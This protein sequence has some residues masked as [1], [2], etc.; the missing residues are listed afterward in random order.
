[1]IR[2]NL[3]L[4]L[5]I[6]LP[7]LLVSAVGVGGYVAFT[8]A[9]VDPI[10]PADA[11]IVLG[12]EHDGREAYGISLAER[13]VA[14]TVVLSNPYGAADPTMKKYCGVETDT[15]SVLCEEPEPSTTR[16]EAIFTQ[17]L[18]EERGWDH[19]VV[20]SWRYHLPRARYIFD[21]CFAGE[22]T[23]QAVPRTYDFSLVH[24]EYTYLYQLAGFTK[25]AIQGDC[26][27]LR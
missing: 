24:W 1:V 22:V 9:P 20:V 10:T 13:G 16:G 23:M 6:V 7:V 15:Y 5:A 19:V 4:V 27:N 8:K 12:G 17:Q 2:R 26:Q 14:D 21:Q 18:A 11:I 3:L 25:A